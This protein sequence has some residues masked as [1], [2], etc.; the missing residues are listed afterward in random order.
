M[1]IEQSALF[2]QSTVEAARSQMEAAARAVVA[3][4]PEADVRVAKDHTAHAENILERLRLEVPIISEPL[5]DP[6]VF[7]VEFSVPDG[8]G[9]RVRS[10]RRYA[11]LVIP[12][13]G[14]ADAFQVRPSSQR[15]MT[16]LHAA[17]LNGTVRW[18]ITINNKTNDQ[19]ATELNAFLRE[20][21]DTLEALRSDMRTVHEQLYAKIIDLLSERQKR[22]Q[23]LTSI[24]A[25]LGT[26]LRT[27]A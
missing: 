10:P 19:V 23:E 26:K 5:Q 12:F 6:R 16:V 14:N 20:L 27:S 8:F 15:Y 21:K 13:T 18:I 2:E 11:E 17:V 3:G 24:G 9:G 4:L 1:P 22:A 7:E 25:A